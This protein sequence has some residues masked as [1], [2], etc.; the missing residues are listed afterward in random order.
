MPYPC[1]SPG[2]CPEQNLK[3]FKRIRACFLLRS[4]GFVGTLSFL[5]LL[6]PPQA[7]SEVGKGNRTE[8][9]PR[10][11]SQMQQDQWILK[12]VFPDISQGYFID[13]GANSAEVFSNSKALEQNGWKGVCVEPFPVDWE[14]RD[15]ILVEEAVFSEVGKTLTFRQ[16]GGRGGFEQTLGKYKEFVK[17]SDPVQLRTTTLTKILKDAKAPNYVHYISLDIEGAE[18]EALKGFSFESYEVGA[19]TIEHNG[20]EPKRSQIRE[21]LEQNGYQRACLVGAEDWYLSKGLMKSLGDSRC[22]LS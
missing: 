10:F 16:A 21:L 4:F 20:E 7:F 14:N 9:N 19:W 15:C 2:T 5:L 18:L 17:K 12:K 1:D 13:V 3:S 22:Q 11:Y 6:S 8:T